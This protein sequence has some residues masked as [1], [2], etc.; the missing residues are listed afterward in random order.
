MEHLFMQIFERRDW[1]SSQIRQQGDS[2]AQSV[3]SNLLASGICPPSSLWNSAADPNIRNTHNFLGAGLGKQQIFSNILYNLP[4]FTTPIGHPFYSSQSIQKDHNALKLGTAAAEEINL[5]FHHGKGDSFAQKKGEASIVMD[6]LDRVQD[7]LQEIKKRKTKPRDSRKNEIQ[8]KKQKNITECSGRMTRSKAASVKALDIS[9]CRENV[10]FLGYAEPMEKISLTSMDDELSNATLTGS[11]ILKEA[12]VQIEEPSSFSGDKMK[13]ASPSDLLPP[14]KKYQ[15]TE[16]EKDTI[17]TTSFQSSIEENFE[18]IFVRQ[19]LKLIGSV[20]CHTDIFTDASASALADSK[21]T[22][23]DVCSEANTIE[24]VF[25][26]NT[27]EETSCSTLLPSE[28]VLCSCKTDV[29]ISHEAVLEL[30][31]F[32]VEKVM[33]VKGFSSYLPLPEG[34]TDVLEKISDQVLAGLE[35]A[36]DLPGVENASRN[37]ET[38]S[39][40]ESDN[41]DLV[42]SLLAESTNIIERSSDQV[43]H[44]HEDAEDHENEESASRNLHFEA[45]TVST[46]TSDI[47]NVVSFALVGSAERNSDDQVSRGHE[48]AEDVLDNENASRSSDFEAESLPVMESDISNAVNCLLVGSTGFPEKSSD[49]VSFGHEDAEDVPDIENASRSSDFEAETLPLMDSNIPNLISFVMVGSTGL[50]EKSSDKVSVGHEDLENLS[51]SENASRKSFSGNESMALE[52]VVDADEESLSSLDV[53]CNGTMDSMALVKEVDGDEDSLSSLHV[54][55]NGKMEPMDL[56]IEGDADEDSIDCVDIRRTST[57]DESDFIC[58]KVG[59]E[60]AE[61]TGVLLSD[62]SGNSSLLSGATPGMEDLIIDK[63]V[64]MPEL[65]FD[66]P[67]LQK[68]SRERARALEL[69]QKSMNKH[70]LFSADKL[71]SQKLSGHEARSSIPSESVS[72]D[73]VDTMLKSDQEIENLKIL[74]CFPMD[75][76]S[77]SHHGKENVL[78]D[79][80]TFSLS[81]SKFDQ[82]I[83][84]AP[85]TPPADKFSQ[86][87]FLGRKGF[88]YAQLVSSLSC[89][90]IQENSRSLKGNVYNGGA[91]STRREPLGDITSLHLNYSSSAVEESK[92]K[93]ISR[94]LRSAQKEL[95]PPSKMNDSK[96]LNKTISSSFSEQSFKHDEEISEFSARR[97]PLED[98]NSL[99]LISS[100]RVKNSEKKLL[101]HALQSA[102]KELIRPSKISMN[103]DEKGNEDT[104]KSQAI[105][106]KKY[107]NIASN[108]HSFVPLVRQKQPAPA[109]MT[110]KRDVKVKALEAA[111]AA[112]RQ[113][114]KKETERKMRKEAMKLER[115]KVEKENARKLELKQKH[116]EEEQKKKEAVIA[117]RKRQR[118]EEMRE[119]QKKKNCTEL[120]RQQTREDKECVRNVSSDEP[121]SQDLLALSGQDAAKNTE[122]K[123][124][125]Q[126]NLQAIEKQRISCFLQIALQENRRS[127]SY[128]ISPYRDSDDEEA[129]DDKRYRKKFIP[130]WARRESLDA[131]LLSMKQ[132]DPRKIFFKKSSFDLAKVLPHR[133]RH[134]LR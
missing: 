122:R 37:P 6:S 62:V 105:P 26:E 36:E 133:T 2:Y 101:G 113:A 128:E 81:S 23:K 72:L 99:H 75:D 8:L 33:P 109:P 111:E 76:Q 15:I 18:D 121:A 27:I 58:S 120:P 61:S 124:D 42:G 80:R 52:Q 43:L 89:F 112:K 1:V 88:G 25:E 87:S 102:K 31:N 50:P 83:P 39:V 71:V 20:D 9:K 60:V 45:E 77:L 130:P 29:A 114:E 5:G 107:K 48:E 4:R 17:P 118:E 49:Q 13:L 125:E 90:P 91:F 73:N 59:A 14:S 57:A 64:L 115:V 79:L 98:V 100:S 22:L 55:C 54:R 65:E 7:S 82:I 96:D 56:E 84:K 131:I 127:Q 47:P 93:P 92:K 24:R 63:H 106:E 134:L 38:S 117:A 95:Y 21:K 126:N 74:K 34:S 104:K 108:I 3:A 41:P 28:R 30:G 110:G 119:R 35:D 97:E 11:G 66:D 78:D 116:K 94:V 85:F 123:Q 69:L 68:L 44:D 86:R 46:M 40:V 53:H 19:E 32:S 103:L 10:D 51:D 70:A 12:S 67:N 129:T 132:M 16:K